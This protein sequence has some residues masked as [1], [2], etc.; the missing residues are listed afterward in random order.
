MIG[1][2]PVHHFDGETLQLLGATVTLA[3]GYVDAVHAALLDRYSS[4][5]HVVPYRSTLITFY[6]DIGTAP[7]VQVPSLGA[8]APYCRDGYNFDPA[9]NK[10]VCTHGTRPLGS[11]QL[12]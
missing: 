6:D 4:D 5:G 10:Y 1:A 11:I 3:G 8:V 9:L 12:P 7:A 2:G